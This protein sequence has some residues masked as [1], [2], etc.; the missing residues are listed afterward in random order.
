NVIILIH[1]KSIIF[2][3]IL[4]SIVMISFTFP[5][6]ISVYLYFNLIYLS[7]IG[8]IMAFTFQFVSIPMMSYMQ[9]SIDNQYKGRVFSLLNTLGNILLP[10]GTLIFGFLY[11]FNIY[12]SVNLFSSFIVII[13][14]SLLLNK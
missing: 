1:L 11:E 6:Y 12:F 9:K 10:N 14:T 3:F 4:L 7:C 2:S 5:V 8:M 13:V